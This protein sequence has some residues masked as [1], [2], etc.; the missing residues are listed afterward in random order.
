MKLGKKI[1]KLR[2][3]KNFTQEHVAEKI[4]MT[5]SNYSKVENDT[6][7]ITFSKLMEISSVLGLSVEDII[8]FN[9]SLVFNLRNNRKAN[10]LVINQISPNEKKVYDEYIGTLKTEN[11]YLKM[12]I[13]KLLSKNK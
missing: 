10:G 9:E 12:M 1:K 13:K 4:S 2:E 8:G 11:A 7:D 3:L 6:V 5:Q